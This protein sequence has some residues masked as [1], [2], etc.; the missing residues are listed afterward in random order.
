MPRI[1]KRAEEDRVDVP[2]SEEEGAEDS[3]LPQSFSESAASLT[4]AEWERARVYVYRLAPKM[5]T[6]GKAYIG[7]FDRPI[8]ESPSTAVGISSS[9]T[10]AVDGC[11]QRPPLWSIALTARR[12][13]GWTRL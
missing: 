3:G 4:E 6:G 9:S 12:E 8:D 11:W 5:D 7:K 1:R 10:T 13:F 2:E